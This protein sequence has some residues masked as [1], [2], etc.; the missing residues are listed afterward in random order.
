MFGT[1]SLETSQTKSE[2]KTKDDELWRSI[3]K[4]DAYREFLKTRRWFRFT[5][6]ILP[7]LTGLLAIPA[8][9]WAARHGGEGWSAFTELAI[10]L[11]RVEYGVS[12]LAPH[13]DDQYG[14]EV[15]GAYALL[16]V[17]TAFW[18]VFSVML[19]LR[20]HLRFYRAGSY[21]FAPY[22]KGIRRHAIV[23]AVGG[24]VL[25]YHMIWGL[26]MIRD[27]EEWSRFRWPPNRFVFVFDSIC[28][29]GLTMCL[30]GLV[31]ALGYIYLGRKQSAGGTP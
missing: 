15:L 5:T 19:G 21:R 29:S 28:L 27:L 24:S 7:L 9:A 22:Y 6:L 26:R 23:S 18:F 8:A 14:R 12:Q 30:L 16:A 10:R 17:L 4:N 3:L 1:M 25:F 13:G 31:V 11:P 2:I 20:M